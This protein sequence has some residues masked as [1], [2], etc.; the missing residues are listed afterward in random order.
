MDMQKHYRFVL[1]RRW[2]GQNGINP[3]G[4]AEERAQWQ[5]IYRHAETARRLYDDAGCAIGAPLEFTR[6]LNRPATEDEIEDGCL[7]H[8]DEDCR[9]FQ[10]AA[11]AE[12]GEAE[13]LAGLYGFSL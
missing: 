2:A 10:K 12:W 6:Y 1:S 3:A 4:T 11:D 13:R 9:R 7:V 5:E 8:S